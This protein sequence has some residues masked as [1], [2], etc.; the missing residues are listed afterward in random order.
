MLKQSITAILNCYRRPNNLKEQV[1]ALRNQSCPPEEIWIWC[2]YH[3]DNAEF[4]LASLGVDKII[5]SSHNFKYHGR[6]TLGLLAQT[7]FLAYFDDDTVPGPR[8]FE[9]CMAT[10]SV[11]NSNNITYPILGS[12]GVV[13][14]S[15]RYV[16]HIRVGWPSKNEKITEVDLVGHS[17]FFHRSTLNYMWSENPISLENGEDIQLS[18]LAKKLGG[19]RTFCPPHPSH[20]KD[21]WGSIKGEELGIDDVAMSNGKVIS[22]EKFFSERDY[23]VQKA[24]QNGWKTVMNVH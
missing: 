24:L 9:S 15:N 8:W 2:N 6:F 12:A 22:H 4:D 14:K 10:I 23:V 5:W 16:D 20:L 3:E 11:L 21:V 1:E 18:F 7:N 13:L 19:R 17:W